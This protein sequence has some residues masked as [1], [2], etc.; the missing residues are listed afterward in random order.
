MSGTRITSLRYRPADRPS[1]QAEELG[2]LVAIRGANR[3]GKSTLARRLCGLE[4]AGPGDVLDIDAGG[5]AGEA[6]GRGEGDGRGD[7][8]RGPALLISLAALDPVDLAGTLARPGATDEA[9]VAAGD[10]RRLA[11]LT[12]IDTVRA[13]LLAHRRPEP[14]W[15]PAGLQDGAG[16][17]VRSAPARRAA[18]SG[19]LPPAPPPPPASPVAPAIEDPVALAARLADLDAAIAQARARIEG[20][21][22][23]DEA[24]LREVLHSLQELEGAAALEVALPDLGS[25]LAS[26]RQHFPALVVSVA[27][28]VLLAALLMALGLSTLAAPLALLAVSAALLVL[29]APPLRRDHATA[30]GMSSLARVLVDEADLQAGPAL[31]GGDDL[32]RRTLQRLALPADLDDA[33]LAQVRRDRAPPGPPRHRTGGAAQRYVGRP[34]RGHRRAC[35]HRGARTGAGGATPAPDRSRCAM[36]GV[37]G[38]P[39]LIRANLATNYLDR[40]RAEEDRTAAA[41]VELDRLR[42]ELLGSFDAAIVEVASR[43]LTRCSGGRLRSLRLDDE[44]QVAGWTAPGTAAPPGPQR[45]AAGGA[46]GATGPGGV[47]APGAPPRPRRRAHRPGRPQPAGGVRGAGQPGRAPPGPRA[48]GFRGG[49]RRPPTGAPRHPG[50]RVA[51]SAAGGRRDRRYP[52]AV[53]PRGLQTGHGLGTAGERAGGGG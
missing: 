22:L 39:P 49:H 5:A 16:P 13:A 19:P 12:G 27:G 23:P 21:E 51:L 17:T 30:H 32:R 26:A 31:D 7:A 34:A 2:P 14:A 20:A 29:L 38:P 46:G 10:P 36:G 35:H 53:T 52:S 11:W 15:F 1:V 4:P 50:A 41:V 47:P 3:S 18:L 37:A 43:L 24:A 33:G 40:L 44:L 48:H 25:F 28:L 8:R 9:A 6:D 45:C 42:A